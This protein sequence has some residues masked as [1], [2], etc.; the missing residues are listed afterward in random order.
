MLPYL[1]MQ[2]YQVKVKFAV[3]G[4]LNLDAESRQKGLADTVSLALLIANI[5]GILK[6]ALRCND[7]SITDSVL[8]RDRGVKNKM[9]YSFSMNDIA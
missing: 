9:G 6:D 3:A 7:C 2:V 4:I 1:Q 8:S 5:Q